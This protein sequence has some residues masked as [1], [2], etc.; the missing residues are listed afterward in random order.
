MHGAPQHPIGDA[1]VS[2]TF[3]G[4]R[5][6]SPPGCRRPPVTERPSFV[7]RHS[8]FLI[9][10]LLLTG[11][12]GYQLGPTG[13]QIAGARSV[14]INPFVNKTIEPRLSE[15][16][17]HALRKQI[18][19]DGTFRLNTANSGDIIVTGDILKYDR[20][21]V[22]LRARD[23]LTPRDYRITITAHITARERVGGKILLDRDVIGRTDVRAGADLNSAELQGI[24]LAADFL[25]VSATSLLADGSW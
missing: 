10:L 5:D 17:T 20:V 13:G 23:A 15:A 3:S 24:P 9:L 4:M 16:I 25:A 12:A 22:A 18:Q 8:S 19:Q 1:E 14:Q 21:A 11:C 6:S 2:T 7:L